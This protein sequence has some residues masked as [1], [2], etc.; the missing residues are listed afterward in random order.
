VSSPIIVALA[1]RDDDAAPLALGCAL[2]RLTGAPLALASAYPFG[3]APLFVTPEWITATREAAGK[4]LEQIAQRLRDEHD[5]TLHVR[6]E[7]SRGRALYDLAIELDAAAI[8]VGSTHRA[9]VGRVLAGDLATGLLHAAH[10]PVAVAPRG[11]SERDQGFRRIGVGFVDTPEGR[12]AL[13]AAAHLA[14]A[15]NASVAAFTVLEPLEWAAPLVGPGADVEQQLAADR[16]KRAQAMSDTALQ[17]LVASRVPATSESVVGNARQVL[18]EQ[19]RE[20]DLLVC[21]SRG[22]GVLKSVVLGSVTRALAH[23]SSCPLYIVPRPQSEAADE[24][25]PDWATVASA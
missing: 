16:I 13:G 10:C 8:V 25:S 15:C 2:A 14:R 20:L 12:A 19:S 18:A 22:Y 7:S 9:A 21:G 3:G 1:L 17:L 11:Y 4:E 24:Q 6:P 5:V 23:S